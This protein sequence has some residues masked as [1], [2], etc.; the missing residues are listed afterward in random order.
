MFLYLFVNKVLKPHIC[1][2]DSYNVNVNLVVRFS[3]VLFASVDTQRN[4]SVR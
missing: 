2:A 4:L 1:V 3:L